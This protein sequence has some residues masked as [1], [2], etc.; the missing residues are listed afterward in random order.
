MVAQTTYWLYVDGKPVGMGKLRHRLTEKLRENGGHV[1][2]AI[3]PMYRNCGY[4][5]LV[6]KLM[7]DEARKMGIGRILVTVQNY[8]TASLQV[9]LANGGIVEKADDVRHYIWIECK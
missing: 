4:G 2:Y 5:K 9:A 8:N 6:L 1:G 7:I 3:A